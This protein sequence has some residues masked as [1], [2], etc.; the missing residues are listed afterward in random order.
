MKKVLRFFALLV[1]IVPAIMLTG[2]LKDAHVWQ[3]AISYGYDESGNYCQ[4]TQVCS[5]GDRDGKTILVEAIEETNA[6]IGGTN[7]TEIKNKNGSAMEDYYLGMSFDDMIAKTNENCASGRNTSF[8]QTVVGSATKAG[9]PISGDIK[10]T[11]DIV[12]GYNGNSTLCLLITDEVT[13]DLNGYSITQQC[14]TDGMS[15]YALFVVNSGAT[16][17]IVDSSKEQTGQ[18]NFAF[19]QSHLMVEL[20]I[21]MM[22]KL[23]QLQQE[24]FRMVSH[25]QPRNIIL[26]LLLIALVWQTSMGE[27]LMGKWTKRQFLNITIID[28][29]KITELVLWFFCFS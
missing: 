24:K 22:E 6:V 18:I 7:I 20:S 15:G 28:K 17:N 13:I 16:L 26:P 25:T 2:C 29:E 1:L 4:Y 8:V 10:L 11:E 5:C 12:V 9:L 27:K 23:K 14:G 3:E 19:G 21:F